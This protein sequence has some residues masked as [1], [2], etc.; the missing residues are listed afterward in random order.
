MRRSALDALRLGSGVHSD[1]KRAFMVRTILQN[2]AMTDGVRKSLRDML[3]VAGAV[4]CPALPCP[5]LLFPYGA[6]HTHTRA[7]AARS[8]NFE[9]VRL[10]LAHGLEPDMPSLQN[11]GEARDTVLPNRN[12]TTDSQSCTVQLSQTLPYQSL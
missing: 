6:P 1:D 5:A 12:R 2:A 9:V 3:T 8:G 11:A 4:P 7:H 10:V